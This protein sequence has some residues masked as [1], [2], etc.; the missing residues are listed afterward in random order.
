MIPKTIHY[1]WFGRNPLPKSVEKCISSWKR[2]APDYD[3]IQHNEDNFDFSSHPY[4]EE[5]YAAHKWAFVS[6]LARL[7]IICEQGGIYLDTDV[8]LI[9]TLDAVLNNSFFFAVEKDTNIRNGE[10]S[11][12]VA[13]GLGF[14]AEAGNEVLKCLIDEYEGSHFILPE[15][16]SFDLTPCPVRNSR[17]LE[18]YGY[19]YQDELIKF[20]GGT[21]YP[22]EYFCP[23]EFSSDRTRYTANTISI[24][25]YDASWKTNREK[26]VN[27]MKTNVKKIL[28]IF[29][30]GTRK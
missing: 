26:M 18:K 8:E 23:E 9:A 14:G 16:G 7:L 4:M 17:A 19:A 24:H 21:I 29:G 27:Q 6:D 13:T 1:C 28:N 20:A 3:I 30:G 15:T 2:Y 22:S 10:E 11:V 25:H 12:H 5:A